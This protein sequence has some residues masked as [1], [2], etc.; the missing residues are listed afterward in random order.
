MSAIL[1]AAAG[2]C[3]TLVGLMAAAMAVAGLR[4]DPWVE[5][6]DIAWMMG[7]GTALTA[8]LLVLAL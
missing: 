8:I 7:I 2:A 4:G 1:L 5:P 3:A 6:A